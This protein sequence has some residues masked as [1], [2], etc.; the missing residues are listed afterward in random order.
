MASGL[1]VISGSVLGAEVNLCLVKK[2]EIADGR[3]GQHD[4][5]RLVWVFNKGVFGRTTASISDDSGDFD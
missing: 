3:F 1:S 4:V 5:L 2:L